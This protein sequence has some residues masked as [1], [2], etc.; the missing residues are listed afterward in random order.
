MSLYCISAV[1]VQKC[2]LQ[3]FRSVEWGGLRDIM[4]IV[5]TASVC[6]NVSSFIYQLLFVDRKQRDIFGNKL[7]YLVNNLGFSILVILCMEM[8][9]LT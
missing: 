7:L 5:N 9:V 4:G 2:L 3:S 1:K 8:T 6:L